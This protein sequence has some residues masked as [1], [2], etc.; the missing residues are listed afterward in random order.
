MSLSTHVA[1][2]C[3][4]NLDSDVI[5]MQLAVSSYAVGS[6][7]SLNKLNRIE[8]DQRSIVSMSPRDWKSIVPFWSSFL[9]SFHRTFPDATKRG[10]LCK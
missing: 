2:V 8:M 7:I 3:T 1:G 4:E 6:S 10:L 9:F 5:A